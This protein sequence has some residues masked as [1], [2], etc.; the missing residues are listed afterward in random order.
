M[1]FHRRRPPP[2]ALPCPAHLL[3]LPQALSARF[4][5]PPVAAVALLCAGLHGAATMGTSARKRWWEH[6]ARTHSLKNQTL[7]CDGK[8]ARGCQVRSPLRKRWWEHLARTHSLKNQTLTCDGKQARGCQMAINL[9]LPLSQPSTTSGRFV[10]LPDF[11]YNW[12]WT[13][14]LYPDSLKHVIFHLCTMLPFKSVGLQPLDAIFALFQGLLLLS[15]CRPQRSPQSVART[16][17]RSPV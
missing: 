9:I 2:R 13:F 16:C 4:S 8:Q 12:H 14:F 5:S 10:L 17:T 11:L 6:L 3:P 15:R 7:T 1:E